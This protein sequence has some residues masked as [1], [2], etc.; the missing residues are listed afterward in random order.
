MSECRLGLGFQPD[1]LGQTWSET[2]ERCQDGRSRCRAVR[3]LLIAAVVLIAGSANAV[4]YA[5]CEAMN[6]MAS[7]LQVSLRQELDD[8]AQARM[9]AKEIA[10]CGLKPDNVWRSG[11]QEC[12]NGVA[13]YKDSADRMA[14]EAPIFEKYDRKIKKIAS[15]YKKA[16]C[17]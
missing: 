5:K 9:E 16:G 10:K 1:L 12:A 4:D 17:L 7:R 15:D 6:S 3:R 14:N 8:F 2:S 11:W 13:A